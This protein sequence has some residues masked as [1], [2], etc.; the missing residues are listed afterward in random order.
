MN[1]NKRISDW[2]LMAPGDN[3]ILLG[4]AGARHVG[5]V[6]AR[7]EDGLVVWVQTAGTGRKLFHLDDG[8]EVRRIAPVPDPEPVPAYYSPK[9]VY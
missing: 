1:E 4:K 7:T 8:F 5:L 2:L 3:V 9:K 6:D